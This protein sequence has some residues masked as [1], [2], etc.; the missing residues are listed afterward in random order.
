MLQVT[1][2]QVIVIQNIQWLS[3]TQELS[4]SNFFLQLAMY[5]KIEA[6]IWHANSTNSQKE[7]E[8]FTFIVHYVTGFMH[9]VNNESTM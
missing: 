1:S 4:G 7:L 3:S 2:H 8:D 5:F 9:K 6:D